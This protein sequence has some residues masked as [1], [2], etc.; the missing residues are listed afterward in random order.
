MSSSLPPNIDDDDDRN[1]G[2]I[3][4]FDCASMFHAKNAPFP[5][6]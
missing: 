5:L 4:L 2:F 6:L 1:A 3:G